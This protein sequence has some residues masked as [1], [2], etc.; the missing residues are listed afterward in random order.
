MW[1]SFIR[2]KDC[3]ASVNAFMKRGSVCTIK[4]MTVDYSHLFYKKKLRHA[5]FC[6]YDIRGLTRQ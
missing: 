3:V 4:K 1:M 5:R 6:Y 2:L